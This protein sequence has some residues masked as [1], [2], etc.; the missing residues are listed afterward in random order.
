MKNGVLDIQINPYILRIF[1]GL[2]GQNT[3]SNS[4]PSSSAAIN[5]LV[6]ELKEKHFFAEWSHLVGDDFKRFGYLSPTINENG[7]A[8]HTFFQLDTNIFTPPVPEKHDQVFNLDHRSV[9]SD[10]PDDVVFTEEAI[11]SCCSVEDQK[12]RWEFSRKILPETDPHRIELREQRR[13]NNEQF[14]AWLEELEGER[15]FSVELPR[16]V[17][18]VWVQSS[19]DQSKP[20]TSLLLLNRLK[21]YNQI[22]DNLVVS[23]ITSKTTPFN[24]ISTHHLSR[25]SH[26][27][28]RL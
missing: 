16:S 15:K 5:G 6:I 12:F 13:Q 11:L 24:H 14:A 10:V 20:K 4:A 26:K 25:D 28:V 23:V 9:A 8:N 19:N 17:P 3:E 1:Y 22:L 2:R 21:E 7:D 27:K 18:N